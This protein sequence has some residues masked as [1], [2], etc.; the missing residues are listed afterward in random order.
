MNS[1]H[2]LLRFFSEKEYLEQF[3]TGSLY[4]NSMHYFWDEY[5]LE[6]AQKRKM[7]IIKKNPC[8]NPDNVCVPL[9]STAPKGQMDILEGTIGTADSFRFGFERE[10][11]EVQATDVMLR[12]VG[13]KYCNLCCFYRYDIASG[14][15]G[16]TDEIKG[17]GDYVAVIK[18]E[19]EFIRRIEAAVKDLDHHFVCGD[20]EY[21]PP[22]KFGKPVNIGHHILLKA[23][24]IKI[25]ITS[26]DYKDKILDKRDCF[27]K[28][29]KFKDQREWRI[30][31]YRGVAS[32]EAYRLE[33]GDISDIVTWVSVD[34]M[35][36]L[37]FR[38]I[39]KKYKASDC[40]YYGTV[41]REELRDMFYA[42]GNN[43][44]E[45]FTTIG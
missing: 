2:V 35:D 39:E 5:K 27:C 45:M 17:F 16:V 36:K 32:T 30:A 3:L 44:A 7:E 33:I 15:M 42:L 40:G 43:E 22:Q 1:K 34:K 41:S 25:D 10:F 12:A 29:M 20:V 11:V 28:G 6:D 26:D 23:R 21:Q 24:D 37:F 19:K 31:L 38:K 14:H 13:Y 4:M 9:E 18:N 8:L